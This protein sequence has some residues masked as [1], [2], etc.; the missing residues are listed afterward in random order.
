M[1]YHLIYSIKQEKSLFKIAIT[2][3][4]FN[5]KIVIITC[6][7]RVFFAEEE[8]ISILLLDRL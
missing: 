4:R 5:N 7:G 1:G 8:S 2:N 6:F 3:C